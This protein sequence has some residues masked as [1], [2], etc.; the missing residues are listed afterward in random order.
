M[1]PIF[2]RRAYRAARVILCAYVFWPM[3]AGVALCC[4][5]MWGHINEPNGSASFAIQTIR[6]V[7]R[8]A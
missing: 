1:H 3:L 4:W 2:R 6:C 5:L 7:A 8:L